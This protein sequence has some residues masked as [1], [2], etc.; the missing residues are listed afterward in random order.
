MLSHASAALVA[1]FAL[2]LS[3]PA[4]AAN[5]VQITHAKALAGNVTPGDAAGYPVTLS[6]PGS[7]VLTGNLQPPANKAGIQVASDDV[8]IDLDGSRLNGALGATTG[9]YGAAFKRVTIRNGTITGFAAHG[10]FATGENWIVEDVR[11]VDNGSRGISLGSY[12]AVRGT[13]VTQNGSTGIL[14]QTSCLVEESNVSANG[15][16][17][18]QMGLGAVLGSVFISNVQVGISGSGI[19]GY[20]N[21]TLVGNNG[22]GANPQV[23]DAAQMHPNLCDPACP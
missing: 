2:S 13:T 15:L 4:F 6:L 10:I 17:G 7:Y 3:A 9:I 18:I 11:V 8:A 16:F 1:A 12:A 21:N 14:C 20:A 22:G 23:D 5:E 19:S